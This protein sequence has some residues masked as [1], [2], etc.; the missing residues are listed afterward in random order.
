MSVYGLKH[1]T[2]K[3]KYQHMNYVLAWQ[4]NLAQ[5]QSA[6]PDRHVALEKLKQVMGSCDFESWYGPVYKLRST[7]KPDEYE[8]TIF[9]KLDEVNALS[10]RA[11]ALVANGKATHE[12]FRGLEMK[13]ITRLVKNLESQHYWLGKCANGSF[14][15]Y[16]STQ[17]MEAKGEH[18]FVGAVGPFLSRLGAAYYVQRD[19]ASLK[20][21]SPEEIER[22]AREDDEG[23]W[24]LIR[25]QMLVEMSM[26]GQEIDDF[27]CDL[28]TEYEAR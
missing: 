24:P 26:T 1:A 6:P 25:E 27:S 18:A 28:A 20:I 14:I 12:T 10:L 23:A 11:L 22:L 3:M 2:P 17:P 4:A 15:R 5:L 7:G 21:L 8:K 9:V 13:E 19:A 16:L